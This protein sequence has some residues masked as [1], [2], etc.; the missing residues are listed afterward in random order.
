MISKKKE[1]YKNTFIF[2]IGTFGSKIMQ[3]ILVP[4]YTVYMTTGE[5]GVADIISSTNS[6]IS[7][8]LMLGIGNGILRFLLNQKENEKTTST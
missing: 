7:P 4:L 3:M 6:L 8:I 1:L 5:F 2:G